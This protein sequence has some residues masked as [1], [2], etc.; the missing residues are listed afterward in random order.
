[1]SDDMCDPEPAPSP[2]MKQREVAAFFK[3]DPRTIRNWTSRGLLTPTK[4]GRT[5]FYSRA[6]VELLAGIS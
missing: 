3:C 6:Q 4:V 2:L 1:M 5:V